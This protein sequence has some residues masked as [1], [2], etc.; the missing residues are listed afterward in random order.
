MD[1]E[2]WS[3]DLD[4][5]QGEISDLM[6]NNASVREHYKSMVPDQVSHKLFWKRYFFK[7]HLIELQEARRNV[8]KKRAEEATKEAESGEDIHFAFVS[9]YCVHYVLKI[10]L[11]LLSQFSFFGNIPLRHNVGRG[12]RSNGKGHLEGGARPAAQRVRA[13][14]ADQEDEER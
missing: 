2:T 1:W 11:S 4:K 9:Y 5:R 10:S 8:L 7:V 14:D 12:R 6:V 13:G 3:C